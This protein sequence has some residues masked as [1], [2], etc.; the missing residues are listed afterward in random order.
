MADRKEIATNRLLRLLREAEENEAA[1]KVG[2]VDE[3]VALEEKVMEKSMRSSGPS[4]DEDLDLAP[5]DAEEKESEDFDPADTG[6]DD[7]SEDLLNYIFEE[8]SEEDRPD[9]SVD[10]EPAERAEEGDTDDSEDI[11]THADDQDW[12]SDFEFEDDTVEDEELRI[13]PGEKPEEH[14]LND[15]G[16]SP[17]FDLELNEDSLREEADHTEMES[18]DFDFE[19]FDSGEDAA[20]DFTGGLGNT[21]EGDEEEVETEVVAGTTGDTQPDTP[22]EDDSVGIDEDEYKIADEPEGTSDRGSAGGDNGFTRSFDKDQESVGQAE[23]VEEY[24]DFQIEESEKDSDE[25]EIPEER[26]ARPDE[27][28]DEIQGGDDV[29]DVDESGLKEPIEKTRSVKSSLKTFEKMLG[30]SKSLSG[31]GKQE[32]AD[33]AGE[34]DTIYGKFLRILHKYEIPANLK[35][36][37]DLPDLRQVTSLLPIQQS[38]VGVDISENALKYVRITKGRVPTVDEY[39]FEPFT[40]DLIEN[41]AKRKQH[42]EQVLDEVLT[43]DGILQSYV[44]TTVISSQISI[45]N[46]TL[47]KVSKSELNTAVQW[48]SKKSLPMEINDAVVDYRVVGEV[49]ESGVTKNDVL[50]VAALE[51]DIES[52]I[53]F[54]ES[55]DLI[56]NKISLPPIAAWNAYRHLSPHTDS[57]TVMVIELGANSSFICIIKNRDLRFVRMIGVA[58]QDF[59]DALTGNIS[60]GES[61][62]KITREMAIELKTQYGIPKPEASGTVKEGI[63]CAQL[64]SR[65]RVPVE[66]LAKEIHRSYSYY[67][68]EISNGTVNK[69][70][71]SGDA[72]RIK[73]LNYYLGEELRNT[74]GMELPVETLNPAENIQFGDTVETPEHFLEIAPAFSV[75]LGLA[76]DQSSLLNMLPTRFKNLPK[77]AI[78][79]LA[80]LFL[81][82]IMVFSMI[83]MSA[84]TNSKIENHREQ[85]QLLQQQ[86]SQIDP[87]QKAF[88][89]AMDRKEELVQLLNQLKKEIQF[90]SIDEKPLKTFSEII[91]SNFGIEYLD[92]KMSEDNSTLHFNLSGNIYSKVTSTDIDLIKFVQK[93]E[94]TGYFTNI[95][96]KKTKKFSDPAQPGMFFE[97]TFSTG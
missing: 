89:A 43:G 55:F 29:T 17:D 75:P 2:E 63:S 51:K 19:D 46:L 83:T 92:I 6:D 37:L 66:R 57:D 7:I 70:L 42:I 97:M 91:P 61:R 28:D 62:T 81:G 69:I 47:P 44:H 13:D 72:A 39:R 40:A 8:P 49:Q 68:K 10:Q 80:T 52:Q 87:Q 16:E 32:T 96:I 38:C 25:V 78:A 93:L 36:W 82:V 4:Q 34:S 21:E 94:S 3:R 86:Y 5:E 58:D 31:R 76:T 18:L 77:F 11:D 24:E 79:K 88:V 90:S 48:A 1:G 60:T 23:D 64:T 27:F 14:D 85:L 56:P 84:V 95:E 35:K 65:L 67:R 53:K 33:S 74:S 30:I 22:E 45:R 9:D 71:L 26:P 59:T 15:T 54:W 50:V 20:D 41:P 12:G 73:N